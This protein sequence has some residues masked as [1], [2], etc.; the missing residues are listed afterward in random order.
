MATKIKENKT[1]SE[2]CRL[3]VAEHSLKNFKEWECDAVLG[4]SQHL[5]NL[6]PNCLRINED[7][8]ITFDEH[9]F[10]VQANHFLINLAGRFKKENN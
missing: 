10:I 2:L 9:F 7:G 8:H 4:G 5:A 6:V 1:Y 3:G